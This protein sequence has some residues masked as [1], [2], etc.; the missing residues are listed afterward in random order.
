MDT[1]TLSKYSKAGK[2]AYSVM[3]YT[4]G[5]LK[6]GALLIEV[7]EKAEERITQLGGKPAFPVDLSIDQIAAHYSPLHNDKL[8]AH[9]L[10]K[11][12]LGVSID[13]FLV[14]M[15]C[16]VDLTPDQRHKEIINASKLA[17]DE[18]INTIK[19]GIKT[20][21]IGIEV[22]KKIKSFGF[23][24]IKNLYGHEL[25]RYDLHAGL[26]VP[27]YDDK[28]AALITEGVFAVEPFA[29]NGVGLVINGKPSEI[30]VIQNKK[31]VRDASARQMLSHIEAEYKTL[32]FS[33]RWLTKK[34]GTRA[35]FSLSI[36]EREGIVHH[37]PQLIEQ[38]GGIVSQ[39]EHTIM[40]T[41]DKIRVL[42]R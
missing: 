12:D 29:T 21:D 22:E 18:A 33:A 9:G 1:E 34:F 5:L 28:S 7:V 19:I 40:V 26:R 27:S 8:T 2:I 10:V 35:L 4:K 25:K 15:A 41:K 36:L 3:Q 32:P 17:L 31:Q 39:S 37:F 20:K 16:S 6:E 30:F 24:P 23:N 42:T 11:I 13:G 38:S 14:D